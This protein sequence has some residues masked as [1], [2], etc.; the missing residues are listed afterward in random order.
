[1]A[2]LY[3][4]GAMLARVKDDF[5][6]IESLLAGPARRMKSVDGRHLGP[7]A[8]VQRVNEFGDEWGYGIEQL[9][10]FSGSV[11]KALQSIEDA[12]D[13]ADTNLAA[14]LDDA[15]HRR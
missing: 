15:S 6:H 1:M 13:E 12:F 8:L 14:A 10:K 9:G 3:I 2:D 11:V 7:D 4:D 5:R